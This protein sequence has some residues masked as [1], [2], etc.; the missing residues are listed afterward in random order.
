[1]HF[2]ERLQGSFPC[3]KFI[4]V[5]HSPNMKILEEQPL[6]VGILQE[7]GM[8]TSIMYDLNRFNNL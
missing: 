5:S 4:T 1:M 8:T 3:L 2:N 6:P 7:T